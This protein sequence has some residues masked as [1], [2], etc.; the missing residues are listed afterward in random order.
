MRYDLHYIKHRSVAL[1][2]RVLL[3]TAQVV[4]FGG[5]TVRSRPPVPGE[6]ALRREPAPMNRGRAP[7]VVQRAILVLVLAGLAALIAAT[8]SRLHGQ[9]DTIRKV[10]VHH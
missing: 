3:D 4:L 9:V 7:R 10:L 6:P 1:D 2:L 5:G 8:G